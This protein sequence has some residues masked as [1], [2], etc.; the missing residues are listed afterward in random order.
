MEK[1]ELPTMYELCLMHARADRA[2]RV[3]VS[4]QLEGQQLTMMEWLALG[5]VAAGPAKEGVSMS[6]IAST[7]DVT[8]PQVTALIGKLLENKMMLEN[9]MIKQRVLASDR[10]G[11]QVMVTTRGKRT[12]TKLETAIA[13]AMRE[14]SKDVDREQLRNYMITVAQLASKHD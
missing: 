2:M 9:K 14:W 3:V 10:R 13:M 5:V 12:L 1:F 7:L 11:R 4:K 6:Q 8:L